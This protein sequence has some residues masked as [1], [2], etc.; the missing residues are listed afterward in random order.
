[1]GQVRKNLSTPITLTWNRV[2]TSL[3][4]MSRQLKSHLR[5]LKFS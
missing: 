5:F 1:M 4:G 2:S 3:K